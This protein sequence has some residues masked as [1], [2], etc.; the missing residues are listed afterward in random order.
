MYESAES[1]T[2]WLPTGGGSGSCL[3]DFLPTLA[4]QKL[5]VVR[6]FLG[7]DCTSQREL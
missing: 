4:R 3:G 2:S 6:S 5:A 1:P 7:A